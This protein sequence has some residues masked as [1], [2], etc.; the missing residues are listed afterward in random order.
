MEVIKR[1]YKNKTY[2]DKKGKERC[3][4]SYYLKLDNGN[5]IAI[6]PCFRDG[7]T[8]LDTLATLQVVGE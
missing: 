2:V 5:Y 7:Y 1:V 4:V 6:N 3:S 8:K